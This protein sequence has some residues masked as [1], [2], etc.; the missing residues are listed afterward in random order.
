MHA[1][2]RAP[3]NS[4]LAGLY[5]AMFDSYSLNKPQLGLSIDVDSD[6]YAVRTISSLPMGRDDTRMAMRMQVP[7]LM[8]CLT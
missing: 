6:L 3:T 2:G 5:I 1:C 8:A 4:S 7:F